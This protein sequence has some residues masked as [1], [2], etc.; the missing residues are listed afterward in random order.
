MLLTFQVYVFLLLLLSRPCSNSS[1]ICQ[2][3]DHIRD[4]IQQ[5]LGKGASKPVI[6]H[7]NRELMHA[8]WTILLDDEF[9][10]AWKHGIVLVCNDGIKRRFYPRIFTYSADYPE[11]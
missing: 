1:R 11:K 2:L 6:T 3:P 7:C 8:L 5:K 10:E 9:I 4:E